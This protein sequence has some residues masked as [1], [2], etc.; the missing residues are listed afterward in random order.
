LF[1][2]ILENNRRG[3]H[4]WATFSVVKVHSSFWQ[5]VIWATFWAIFFK[6]SSGHPATYLSTYPLLPSL[7]NEVICFK[8]TH[9][10]LGR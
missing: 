1:R 8:Y 5:K 7:K 10:G 3:P 2:Q 9:T 6:N 4:F